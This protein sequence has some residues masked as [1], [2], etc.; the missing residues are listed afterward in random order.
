MPPE[1]VPKKTRS[2]IS[3]KQKKEI[4]EFAK[5]NPSFK[6]Y[7]IANEFMK[8]YQNLKIDRTTVTKILNK[9]DKYQILKLK[10]L[11]LACWPFHRTRAN[12][13][14]FTTMGSPMPTQQVNH[15]DKKERQ[16][17]F[18]SQFRMNNSQQKYF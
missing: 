18:G 17:K 7:E 1:S 14:N 11:F 2:R 5:K 10:I 3:D 12:N 8:R 15:G 9:A 6:H 16:G 13:T 4:C